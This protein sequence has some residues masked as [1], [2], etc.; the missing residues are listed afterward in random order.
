ML[1]LKE[2]EDGKDIGGLL[3]EALSQMDDKL[4]ATEF[5]AQGVRYISYAIVFSRKTCHVKM[6][7]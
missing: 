6:K 1:E 5:K 7:G 4:Y 2:L 3:D